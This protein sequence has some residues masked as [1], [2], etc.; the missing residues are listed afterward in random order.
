MA[1]NDRRKV[2]K[3]QE[4]V[5]ACKFTARFKQPQMFWQIA[6]KLKEKPGVDNESRTFRT[7]TALLPHPQATGEH[8]RQRERKETSSDLKRVLGV[9][10]I[11]LLSVV[12]KLKG[13]TDVKLRIVL[14]GLD[15]A[16]ETTLL[17]SLA[18][19]DIN[20]I[21]PTQG[22]NIKSVAS[23]GMKMNV[24]DIGGQRKIHAFRKTY[25]E[26]TDLLELSELID[27]ENL[28]GVPLLALANKQDLTATSPARE[29]AEGV[30]PLS[31]HIFTG[32]HELDLQQPR[33]QK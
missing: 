23:H 1:A 20:T 13:S 30:Q 5:C 22:F 11:G 29:I 14:L 25:L 19:E 33:K 7:S 15:Y 26:N 8:R 24:L 16:G 27:E 3:T 12:Q 18:S 2:E 4:R 10:C 17:K 21:T 6:E 32:R 28:A 31:P 9:F